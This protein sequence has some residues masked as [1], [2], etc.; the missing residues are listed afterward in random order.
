MKKETRMYPTACLSA[1]CG[2]SGADC[3]A[4]CPH[5]AALQEFNAW[6]AKTGAQ[7]SDP[8]WSPNLYHTPAEVRT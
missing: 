1:F 5:Y 2:C 8:I 4:S 7:E 3:N 6:V